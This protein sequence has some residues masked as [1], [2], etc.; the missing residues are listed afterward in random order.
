MENGERKISRAVDKFASPQ[1][2]APK[3]AA[4][5]ES[6]FS[7]AEGAEQEYGSF[8]TASYSS[9]RDSPSM[10]G[11]I[12]VN[13]KNLELSKA[14]TQMVVRPMVHTPTVTRIFSRVE[15]GSLRGSIFTLSSSAI[16]AG[17]LS[18]PLVM[19]NTGLVMGVGLTIIGALLALMS[20]NMLVDTAEVVLFARGATGNRQI[21]YSELVAQIL[22][23]AWG[24]TLEITL[25]VYCFGT[26]VGYLLVIGKAIGGTCEALNI[27]MASPGT[28]IM[29][30]AALALPLALFRDIS[31]LAYS[32][33]LAICSMVYVCMS[34]TYQGVA[35]GTVQ[36]LPTPIAKIDSNFCSSATIVF[37]A[38]NCHVNVFSIYSSLHYPLVS[39]MKKVT[40]RAV[41]L[42]V[43]LYICVAVS[44][45]LLFHDETAGNILQ[46]FPP[47]NLM[48]TIG[49]A[50]V[51]CALTASLPL[52]LHPARENFY[53]LLDKCTNT[54]NRQPA[55]INQ[56]DG[57][58]SMNTPLLRADAQSEE[59]E[60]ASAR[61]VQT[62]RTRTTGG[63]T[64]KQPLRPLLF[65]II[66]TL[67]MM[68]GALYLALNVPGVSIVFSFLGATACVVICYGAKTPKNKT[69]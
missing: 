39:R 14:N 40:Q 27:P 56:N 55:A 18:L 69:H 6:V 3:G 1:L 19:K 30:A 68:G 36:N 16:G 46:N 31:S 63:K 7:A 44:G 37:F 15:P 23:P 66:V 10:L 20:M 5:G 11:A 35:E 59:I 64:G 42:E 48:M 12:G 65:H 2:S 53:L 50:G 21:S 38:Y 32:S 54:L 9:A 62:E 52:C 61:S 13:P 43:F 22:G 45:Y 41:A 28:P 34:I 57:L 26:I 25:V 29:L 47:T 24:I 51:A 17:V 58:D 67:S 60:V 33:L 8:R 4:G 49:K